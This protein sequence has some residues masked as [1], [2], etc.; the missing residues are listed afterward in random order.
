MRRQLLDRVE[1]LVDVALAVALGRKDN[2]HGVN[3]LLRNAASR[4]YKCAFCAN[5]DFYCSSSAFPV[6]FSGGVV[7]LHVV[8]KNIKASS[9]VHHRIVYICRHM[10]IS[11]FVNQNSL[12]LDDR[13]YWSKLQIRFLL[14]KRQT[15]SSIS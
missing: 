5:V 6:P 13:L 4:P 8:D 10:S 9:F 2:I 3:Y 7:C 15:K 12:H 1:A 14:L 11:E